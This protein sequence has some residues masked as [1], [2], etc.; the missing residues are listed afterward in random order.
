[1]KRKIALL[2]SILL[3]L[4]LCS[5][6][7]K[8]PE[9]PVETEDDIIEISRGETA[10]DVNKLAASAV[11]YTDS[12]QSADGSVNVEIN[13]EDAELLKA[14]FSPV[15]VRPRAITE[16]EAEHIARVLF[17]DAEILDYLFCRDYTKAE[18][19]E[20]RA[21]WQELLAGD[22][23]VK[24]Y[25]DDEAGQHMAKNTAETIEAFLESKTLEKAPERI[26]RTVCD[27]SFKKAD[28][29]ESY[30][31]QAITEKDGI[32]YYFG[33]VNNTE[34]GIG[35]Y[36]VSAYLS[37]EY[38]T[39]NN[40][41]VHMLLDSLLSEEEP[42][43]QQLEAVREK[44]EKLIDELDI[45]QWQIDQCSS[46]TAYC[47]GSRELKTITVTAL[48][49][50][51]N[52][53]VLRQPQL[54]NLRSEEENAQRCYYQDL[55][56]E[57]APDGTLISFDYFTPMELVDDSGSDTHTLSF[58]EL[59]GSI[60]TFM[61]QTTAAQYPRPEGTDGTLG[62]DVVISSIQLGFT[63]E[64]IGNSEDYMLV[65][66][67]TVYGN[68]KTTYEKDGQTD[69]FDYR[70]EKGQDVLLMTF[71]AANGSSF[72]PGNNGLLLG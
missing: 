6:A 13:L 54:G 45:G 20:Q 49:L 28:E 26:E 32:P 10:A 37:T 39:P 43:S 11:A 71:D 25:G 7:A 41:G 70:V 40:M 47:L 12:F 31:I 3:T 18:L 66:S 48:P 29:E 14:N 15:R 33:A 53:P 38:N 2:L 8:K 23:L 72:V 57:F 30:E 36:H 69:S 64:S 65:P 60:K 58:A 22:G 46:R 21:L 4:T 68:Y 17:G 61:S 59:M 19:E 44:A 9:A 1:M 51:N 56:F 42:T 27:F 52:I 34:G 16:D 62:T 67:V 63:R 5:C 50:Y 55:C 24:L 35:V